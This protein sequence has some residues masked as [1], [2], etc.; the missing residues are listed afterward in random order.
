M[1]PALNGRSAIRCFEGSDVIEIRNGI[2]FD[3]YTGLPH[4]VENE[5]YPIMCFDHTAKLK[6]CVAELLLILCN[7]PIVVS[8]Y[9]YT[10]C[11][12]RK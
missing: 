12:H 7:G 9:K 11:T 6:G 5:Q 3:F 2:S 4:V 8:V 10:C 1:S